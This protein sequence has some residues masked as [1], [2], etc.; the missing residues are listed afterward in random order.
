M[1]NEHFTKIPSD[2]LEE[3]TRS[4]VFCA[5]TRIL[6]AIIRKT[7]GWN[8]AEDWISLSQFEVITGIGKSNV[9]RTLNQ[10]VR[11]KIIIKSDNKY[12]INAITKAWKALSHPI[13][14]ITSDTANYQNRQSALSHLTPTKN[15]STKEHSLQ[16]KKE[17]VQMTEKEFEIFW[18]EY[19]KKIGRKKAFD[20]FIKI[21]QTIFP[22]MLD[23]LKRQKRSSAW[24]EKQGQFIPHAATWLHGERWE[25]EVDHPFHS[26]YQGYVSTSGEADLIVTDDDV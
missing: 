8:K 26:G 15:N 25:D 16:K 14:V 4:H 6:A 17:Y 10:L 1:E 19:P 11:A 20:R 21:P 13:L 24:L 2:I 7:M 22:K 9:C 3:I 23:A 5:R 18:H 12:R